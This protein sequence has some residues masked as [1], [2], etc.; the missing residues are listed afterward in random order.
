M[1]KIVLFWYAVGIAEK[2]MRN[3]MILMII[4]KSAR[5]VLG[6]CY[7]SGLITGKGRE[8]GCGRRDKSSKNS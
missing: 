1:T 3:Q 8:C 2:I 7:R 4:E 5:I 6:C